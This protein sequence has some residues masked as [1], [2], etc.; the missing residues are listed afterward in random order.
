MDWQDVI[1]ASTFLDLNELTELVGKE[2]SLDD[3]MRMLEKRFGVKTEVLSSSSSKPVIGFNL[4]IH[5][6]LFFG[7]SDRPHGTEEFTI[8]SVGIEKK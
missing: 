5:V 7:T 6:S 4:P 3:I 8:T 2:G 1:K